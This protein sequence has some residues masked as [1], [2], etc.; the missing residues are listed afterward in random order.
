MRPFSYIVRN[1][2]LDVENSI[3]HIVLTRYF[4]EFLAK[5]EKMHWAKWAKP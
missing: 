5:G 1:V 2:I 4:H 3:A